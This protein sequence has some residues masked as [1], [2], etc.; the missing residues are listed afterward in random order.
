MTILRRQRYS[1]VTRFAQRHQIL[2]IVSAAVCQRLYVVN[3]CRRRVLAQKFAL[4]AKRMSVQKP[5][6]QLPPPRAVTLIVFD[7][8][9]LIVLA[10]ENFLMFRAI[11]A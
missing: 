1:A 7:A 8:T 6:S 4:L 5:R 3:F 9:R 11:A 2:L 10:L